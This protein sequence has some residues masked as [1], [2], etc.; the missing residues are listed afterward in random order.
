MRY[1]LREIYYWIVGCF[2]V[3]KGKHLKLQFRAKIAPGSVTE[4]YNKLS[5]HSYFSGELGY[6]SYI[7]EYSVVVGKI[8]RFCS[9]AGNVR[10]LTHTHPVTTFVSSHPAFYSLKAQSGFSFVAEQKFTETPLFDGKHSIIVGNDVY[11]GNGA[12]IIGPVS[13][14]DGAVIAANATVTKD[15]PPYTIVGGVPAHIIRKR[16]NDDEIEYLKKIEWW[17][18]D[19]NWIKEHADKFIDISEFMKIGN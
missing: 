18:K 6:A 7:G 12:T 11:I 9:I 17:N 1:I 8:G 19:L 5:H 15:V 4:G 13:I 10:F 16:F 2:F 3:L 14:G